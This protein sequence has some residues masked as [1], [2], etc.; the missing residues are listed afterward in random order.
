MPTKEM[1]EDIMRERIEPLLFET[2]KIKDKIYLE[3]PPTEDKSKRKKKES[4]DTL[5]F[6]RFRG[7]QL[8]ISGSN[9]PSNLSSRFIRYLVRRS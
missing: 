4:V 3:P 1:S 7:G 2:T 6:K 9:S 8:N 5:R